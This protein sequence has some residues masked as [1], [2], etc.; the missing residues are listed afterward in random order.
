MNKEEA[1]EILRE[2]SEIKEKIDLLYKIVETKVEGEVSLPQDPY[3][4]IKANKPAPDPEYRGISSG[5]I[6]HGLLNNL[7]QE[8][9]NKAT[10]IYLKR[11]VYPKINSPHLRL[12]DIY[13][14]PTNVR[15]IMKIL[16]DLNHF[17]CIWGRIGDFRGISPHFRQRRQ[18]CFLHTE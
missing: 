6:E 2:L 10:E 7:A 8:L 11:N 13:K 12:N 15:Q 4:W 16:S 17:Y 18:S 5:T 3:V 9:E 1:E 14:L